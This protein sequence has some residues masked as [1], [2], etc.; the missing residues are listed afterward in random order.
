[1]KCAPGRYVLTPFAAP[2]G[3]TRAAPMPAEPVGD[4]ECLR[5]REVR[6][7]CP[8]RRLAV[9]PW[10]TGAS[11]RLV[12][13]GLLVC[14]AT[15]RDAAGQ[16]PS[17]E[18]EASPA[19]LMEDSGGTDVR[20][21]AT[22][23]ASRSASTVVTLSLGGEARPG[24]P[25][26]GDYTVSPA[27]PVITIPS[28][29]TESSVTLVVNPVDDT[30]WEQD[31][32]ITVDGS[33]SGVTVTGDFFVIADDEQAPGLE[34]GFDSGFHRLRPGRSFTDTVALRLTGDSTFE[35]A[36]TVTVD[37]EG[38]SEYYTAT[39]PFPLSLTLPAGATS[40]KSA[41]VRVE[42]ASEIAAER[43]FLLNASFDDHPSVADGN[44]GFTIRPE[45]L[46]Y[47]ITYF[48][49]DPGSIAA[50]A[51]SVS[52]DATMRIS[53]A[54]TEDLTAVVSSTNTSAVSD[55]F[56]FEFS[57]ET[58]EAMATATIVAPSSAASLY[59]TPPSATDD[60][61]FS[62]NI[63]LLPVYDSML[64]VGDIG[65]S[66][67][68][69]AAG[70]DFL[71]TGGYFVV[72]IYLNQSFSTDSGPTLAITLDSGP[73]ITAPCSF[74]RAGSTTLRCNYYVRAGD[75]DEDKVI[76][77]DSG[78]LDFGG[79]TLRSPYD[80]NIVFATPV[81]PPGPISIT[82]PKR[83]VGG[84]DE[85][86][87][88]ASLES[89]QEGVGPAQV[90]VTATRSGVY[91][92][93]TAPRNI[94]IPL[95]FVDGT[96]TAGDYS[97][98]GTRT[99]TI[100]R[101]QAS[102]TTTLT[103]TAVDDFVKENRT[104]VVRIE[105]EMV[106]EAVYGTALNVIDAPNILLSALP[107]RVAEDGGVQTVTVTA[108]LGDPTDSVRPRPIPVALRLGGSAVENDDFTVAGTLE[109]TIPANQRSGTTM[110]TLTPVD[111]R[112]LE[113]S[114]TIVLEG[115]TAGL[116]VVGTEV[117]LTDD[118]MQPQV[119]LEVDDDT[120]EE[121]EASAT[122][123]SVTAR[124]DPSVMVSADTVVTL[125]LGGTATEGASG[126][127]TASW[128]PAARQLTVPAGSSESS[129]A[130]TLTLTPRQDALPEGDETIV[131]EGTAEVSNPAM[132][133]LS[134]VVARITLT[135]DDVAGVEVTPT[136]LEIDE[137]ESESYMVALE[138][139]P[140]GDVTFGMTAALAG[141]DV[142][143]S[144]TSL[145]F[146]TT[147]WSM[148]QPVTVTAAADADADTDEPVTLTHSVRG[149]GYDA[150]DDV[151][152]VVVTIVEDDE[153]TFTLDVLPALID[154]DGGVS[155]VTV[156]TVAGVTSTSEETITLS[157][158]GTAT[159]GVDYRVASE[160]LV[161]PAGDTSVTTTVTGLDD[162]A[163]EGS[164]TVVVAATHAGA[165]AGTAQ[166]ITLAEST[167]PTVTL[168]LAPQSIGEN[169]GVSTVTA[170]LSHASSE[171]VA[172]TVS[173]AAVSPAV[174]GDF[175]LSPNK[176]LT[177]A[178]GQTASTG[179]VTIS[180]V[181]NAVDSPDK[182]VTVSATVSGG[183]GAS[184]PES[185]T[186]TIEDD[187]AL[188][189]VAL[190]LTPSSIG[191][192]GGV[193]TV[194]ATLSPASSESVEVTVSA[195]AVSPAVSGDFELSANLVLTIAA[196]ETT[197][198]GTVTV[199]AVNNGVDAPNKTVTVSGSVTGGNGVS[200]P[201][202]QPLTI[203][204]DETA[205]TVNLVLTPSSIGEN[206]GVSTV[207]ATLSPA[208]SESV[209]VTVSAAA[210]SPAVSGDFSLSANRVL[211]I[212]AGETT[213]TG[214]VTVTAVN[215]GVDAP[216]KTVT[217]SGSVTGGNG[218]SAPTDRT[219]TIS[220]DET[221]PTVNLV[222]TPSSIGENGGVSTVTATLSP[223][224]SESVAVTM[225]AT[226]DS[227]AVS[228][229]FSLSANRVLTIAAGETTSTGTVTVTA[230]NNAV[231]APNKTV[232]VSASVTG[233]NGVSAPTDR[234]LTIS[235]DE[236][237]P[238]VALVLTPSSIGENGGVSTVTATLSPASSESVAV[239]VSATAVSP[240]VS[241]DFSLSANQVLTIAAG[242]TT[243]TGTVTITAVNNG[244]DAP[245]K[246][247]TVSGSATGGNG[248]SAPTD[249]TL[250]ISD[251]E[252]APTVNLVL[253]PS[254][255]GENGGVSTVTAT[256]SGVSSEAVEV[257]VSATPVSPAVSGDFELSA[258]L[259]LT[260]AA[261]ETTS[262]GTVTVTAVNNGVDAPAKTVT[263][264][265]SVTGGNGVSAPT[266]QTL[267]ISDDDALPTVNLALT[268][269]S[270][271][272]N[273]G[274]ST[275]TATLS[276]VS[277]ES[278]AVT[279]SATADSPAVSG[280]FELS[281]NQ[282]LTI[283]AG[284]T[285]STGTVTV[286][287]VNNGVDAPNKT[288]TV[289]ASVTGGNGV[290]APSDQVLTISDD[291][292]L[293]T[294]NLVL[295]PSSIGENGGVST[296]T[297]TLSGVSS[298]AVEVTV[299]ATPVS[300][301]VSGD[302]EL[303]ANQVLTIAAG[304][305][306]STGTVTV[307][308]V[309][310]GVDAP[311][312]T[313][314][315]SASVTGGNGVSAPSDQTLTISDDDAL[316]TV[317]LVLAP[318]SIGED[319]GV[320]TV[321][322]TLSPASSEAVEV[323]VSATADSPA[324]SGDFE[325]SANL[326]LTIAA[327]ET[328]STGTVTVT[329]VNNGVDAPN[330][331]VTVSG[332][333]TGGNGASAPASR[334][335]TIS[336]DETTPT[337]N[338]VLTPSSIGE[339]GGVSTVTATLSP[340]SSE[341]V[342]VT[343]SATADSP[344]V[345]GDFSLSPNLVLTI[346]AG[347]TTSTGTVTVT[348]VNNAVDAP[349]KTVTVSG[350]VTGGNGVS[351]P[352]DRTLTISDD[353]TAPTVNLVLT[354]SSIGENG[355]VST[356][357]ATLS[358]ASSES[359]AVTVSATADSPA[360]SG[361]FSLSANRVLTIGAGQTTSTGTVTVTAVNNA[362]DAPNKTV[363]V[364]GSVTGGNGVSAPS[365]QP[366]TISDDEGA[367]TVALVLTP[368]SIGENGG[369][370]T[371]TATL[372]PASSESVAVTVSATAV[373]PAVSGDF[374]LSANRVLTIAA[375][376]R[377]STGTVT[378]TA[379]NNGV[380][381][382]NK[383]VTVSAS[384]T[385]GNGVSVPSDQTLTISDD[386]ALP[387]VSL[388]L[389][390]S[391]IGENGGVSTVTATLSGVSS[392]S[393]A[394]T[395]SATA[396]SPAVSG[397][398]SLSANRVLTIA[399]GQRSSTGTVTITAVNNAVDAPNKTVTVSGSVTGGNGASAPASR[400]LTISDD[401][402]TPTVN[403][404]LTPS[405]IGENG[406]VSTV[407]ATLSPASSE[408]VA[409][410]VSA[411]AV[412]PAVSGDFSLS[413]N[414]V[415]TI[416][417]G[418]TTST[419]TVTVTAVN[420]AVDAPNKT[421]TVSGSVTGGNGV[422]APTDRTL[423]ISDDETAPTVNLVLTP[424][425]IGENGGV[426]TVT[427][428][429]SGVSSESV[430]V[431]VS[432]TA[433]SPAVSGDFSLSANRVL[434]I[435]AGQTTSTG[436]VTITAVNNAVD[437]PAKTVTVSGS[438]TGGNGVSAPSDQP[439]T[440]SDDETTP[441]VA[442]A[443][444]P[445]SIGENGGV[446][447]VTATLSPASSEAVEVTVSATPLSPAV[448]DDFSLSANRVL[449]IAA[450]QTTSTGTVTI[451]A[452]N[453]GVDAP[454]KTVT[455]SG[456]VSGGNGVSAPGSQTLT[457]AD[458]EG[459]P[460]VSLV[461]N[462]SSVSEDDGLSTV[463]ATLSGVSSEAVTLMVS[464]AAVPPT[465]SGDFELSS[466]QV[467]TIAAGET[468][469]T[470]TVT[471]T[472]VDD[473]V[474]APNKTVR[475]SATVSGGN[476][477]SAPG[478][479][480]LTITDDEGAPTVSLVLM[481]SSIGENGGVSTV[482]ATL[483][484][485]SSEAVEVTVSATPV[486]P[487]VS[488]DF[489]L[490]ANPVLTIA[491]GQTASSGTVTI[492]AA[493]NAVDAP[494]K[495]VTVSGSVTGGNGLEAP[496]SQTLTITDDEGA[497]GVSL[498]LTP[499]S[500]GE[501]GGVSTVTATLSTASSETVTV[502]VSG[503]AVSP[504]VSGDFEL[505]AN[506]VLTIV[507]GQTASTGE[508]TITAVDDAVDGPAKEV[509]VSAT[510]TGGNGLEAP[511]SQ[512]LTIT[513][514]E[515]APGVSLV[516]TPPSIS[517][518]GGVSTVTATLSTASSE[519]VTV[520]VSGEAVSP[521]VSGDFEL[522]ANREL[523]ISAGQMASTGEVTITAVD[524]AVGGPG[525]EV[526]VSATVD[527]GNGLEAP[528]PQTLT[529]TDD[530]GALEVSLVL[531][532]SSIGENGGVSTVTATLS[533]ASSESVTVMVSG[534]A[535]SPAVS[536]DFELSANRELT[537]AAGQTAST[538][539]VTI[540]AVDDEL[541]GPNK[542]VQVSGS[543]TGG[544]GV[545]APAP[546]TLT[547]TED[548]EPQGVLLSVEPSQVDEG[549]GDRVV[550][551]TA[552]HAGEAPTEETVL[553]VSIAG[554]T[555]DEEDDFTPVEQFELR[556]PGS[557]GA[558]TAS[559]TLT[560][561]DDEL[562][563]GPETLDVLGSAENGQPVTPASLTIVDDDLV[564]VLLSVEPSTVGED[565]GETDVTVT[566]TL[567]GGTRLVPLV[568]TVTVSEN[569]EQYAV[570][571]AVF[572]VE[573]PAEETR[574]TGVFVL[575]PVDDDEEESDEQVMVTGT[576]K[577]L[578]VEPAAVMIR[579]DDENAAPA[580]DR[581]RHVFELPENRSG[582]ETP[583]VLG[584]VV[585]S[586]ADGDRL[587]YVLESGDRD[588]FRIGGRD[589]RVSYVGEGED[590]EADA[591]EYELTV[592]AHDGTANTE[593]EVLVRVVDLPEAP[594]AADDRAETPEDTPKVID[595]LA[596]DSD[597]DGDRL[598][599]RSVTAPEHG[600]AAVVSGGVR[601]EPELNWHG[602]DRFTYTVADPGGLTSRATVVVTV[603][604]VNDPPE[605][606]DD[607]AE[608]LEDVPVVVDVLANDTDVDGDPLRVVSVGAAGH[609]TT[610]AAGGGV[611][612]ASHL[613]WYGT[614]RFTYTIADPEGLTSTATVTMTVLPVNDP[615]EA[616]GVIPDQAIEEG[617][618]SASVELLPY[619][620]DVDGDVLTYEAVSSDE[621]AVTV[622]VSGSTL[623]LTAV[624]TGTAVVTVTAS[625]V[626]GLTATQRFGV[627]VGDRL[628]KAV[629]TD[630]LAALGRGHL[631]SARMTIGRLLETDGG[632]MTRLMVAGQQ[633]SLGAW[634]RMGAGGL[635]QTHELLFRAATLQQR[636]SA[637]NLV[638]TSADPR[639]RRP[640]ASGIMGGGFG[641]IGGDRNPLFQGTDV[642]LSF[643]G[644]DGP[645]GGGGGA[646]RWRVW[647]QGDMQSFRGAATETSGYDGDLRTAY[648]GL[649]ARLNEQWLAGV[650]VARSGG[651]GNW[652]VGSSSGRLTT[653]LT[654]LH[655]YL[656][657][658]GQDTAVWAL[659]GIGRGTADN[660]RA[661]TGKRGA[662]PLSLALGLVEARRRLGTL[663]GRV[664]LDLRGEA[665]WARLATGGGDETI[666]DLAAGVRRV[667]TGVEVTLPMGG[668]GGAEVAPFGA[669]STRHDGG[670]GQTGVGLEFAGG[671]RVTHGTVRVEAQ[672]R[673]LAL[674][675]ATGY[676][677]R[678]FG[679][680]ATVGGGQHEPGLSASLR[681]HWGAQG[682][683]AET[684]WQEQFQA[685]TQDAGRADAG[686]DGRVGY[687][688]RMPGGR[689]LTPF[690]GYGRMGGGRRLQLG[691]NLGMA[692]LFGG[693]LDSPVQVEFIGER[694]G[695]PGVAP[696]HRVT[697]FGI[698]NFGA[699]SRA[700][701][702]PAEGACVGVA[703]D[704]GV[705]P[706]PPPAAARDEP[707]RLDRAVAPVP[708]VADAVPRVQ[709]GTVAVVPFVNASGAPADEWV[710]AGM[711]ETLAMAFQRLDAVSIFGPGRLT[712]GARAPGSG[713]S[714][715]GAA[716]PERALREVARKHGASWLVSGEY[717]RAGDQVWVTAYL[718]DTGTGA[719][720][721]DVAANGAV[722]DL[723]A[724][725]DRLGAAL[726]D[727]LVSSLAGS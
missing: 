279:V 610:A 564:A 278:V 174:A 385:G 292:A 484:G 359:V 463:T 635:E 208:S 490:S 605:A 679:V 62:G 130:V 124:L 639:L 312:K 300:P 677:E 290:S 34:I 52:V 205:P 226:A 304:Q 109:V 596:N 37:V 489:E 296:V 680:T 483:S 218:V 161:L 541:F 398:F 598:R 687:G 535:V 468:T 230:V 724:L 645:A 67:T 159:K 353:E 183:K 70:A 358:P 91:G 533:T 409:V 379:V 330:K 303:S 682:V 287:A 395:V 136:A 102:G 685:Y 314:T 631:S 294:V 607:E 402:T 239:T 485:V 671:L 241:G 122:M 306:S 152:D 452:V 626:E 407:T 583:V 628:V 299:S 93:Q 600:T 43:S 178:A 61:F 715:T 566:A 556:I 261:G 632:A 285:T 669:V 657:W 674:H 441:T 277:S 106:P 562:N 467:L 376:Q 170:S 552:T 211:T 252:T 10:R 496:A 333:V 206:G 613:N 597:A 387:T 342:A 326:V 13:A 24:G 129:S 525:K 718:V 16:Q 518:N 361:D 173:G 213:S 590:Y 444:T 591:P 512:T 356:V 661:L 648:L 390:P 574:G 710:G 637:T 289:S 73:G 321:T 215:N 223:A 516:L 151:D 262:T 12:L 481:P 193:S 126:D 346:A 551:V 579:D 486:S 19:T 77:L 186:L 244:V 269:S 7:A 435:A 495:T 469:S 168:A 522:S 352:T 324:V 531:T 524:D 421:V 389:T 201:P 158:T 534:E 121:G 528:A 470:G 259:V 368:S 220:D 233:G 649:D 532:P 265:G 341:S 313:V 141:T 295:A 192:N 427:A 360:V 27:S 315:V 6:P 64:S 584:T 224:S 569:A 38:A 74:S 171:S 80:D 243:S 184:A 309:N 276:G 652:E 684:L 232:T 641:G 488:G 103:V 696:D 651:A 464:A 123:V 180:A 377:S 143:V 383:T 585:A 78:A 478:S 139:Q 440:I 603:T 107:A 462:P 246:T 656:R 513:D 17:V 401:E 471:V 35:S 336:D 540:T 264:S 283:A 234:T 434:T 454:N 545:E 487:A 374:S 203:S 704:R 362:V 413:A 426:S 550:Q 659:A 133:P 281:A 328:T 219:L 334:R 544:N 154:E 79:Q 98:S 714:A 140:T 55:P 236:T 570:A 228:G 82:I 202:D 492:T 498:V 108:A 274:V 311:N 587:R 448:S 523:T 630:A 580:F 33:A 410:T 675:T 181:N 99:I 320:S 319:G 53:P 153:L 424:S 56:V 559:F 391:S 499:S 429:L 125:D 15:A 665:S 619:F 404:V 439:L 536:G 182:E 175:S 25:G 709:T 693:D 111:D 493:D 713:M 375:G 417:A 705:A 460:T 157:L 520:T 32:E 690:G 195:A 40:V 521:A 65:S 97:V 695:R 21:T 217:V 345:S 49:F 28:G 310:N 716:V 298:E 698:V 388:V 76:Q 476:G 547:I 418:E 555:A 335:L 167:P 85:I 442:L 717:R 179:T 458:D 654:V 225:S 408:S 592:S 586:D 69:G 405:S 446:S 595:V 165:A 270:I 508:V 114:E 414:L 367:P 723:F 617:G 45:R 633:L 396:D 30:Y 430:A 644:D 364:S 673:M 719:R 543:V 222:L 51:G 688:L 318:Q 482:T 616:V 456:S 694:Y 668:P 428:T 571:P 726:T 331:T 423:T 267:T 453:D 678:G 602:K 627:Q 378:I 256:L 509:T 156:S 59:F 504:A 706:H 132:D 176:V 142:S 664:E 348:A 575:T 253:T 260:I 707:G 582:R 640:G 338:L 275:V 443:L 207:T 339:N 503:E 355:G 497:P 8:S 118:D 3:K 284:E 187:D 662:S 189:T 297:A 539:E 629:L 623:T 340:A 332:S 473:T 47:R 451:T 507:A 501:N 437:A 251:D 614:D 214:T 188:P 301:A 608:T 370:S 622:A 479:Q 101:G 568:V 625:D 672:G 457:I 721:A 565:A 419:G 445:S 343:V 112:L 248:V 589:G 365:D 104:E 542:Q 191:E 150:V 155:T 197:S 58:T 347:Q 100:P 432:A 87:L 337:V 700:P 9:A 393:V 135:D 578:E 237:A 308:A 68:G 691:A 561:V 227:P 386:D 144:P 455:V 382:P 258:N 26:V 477:V 160:T 416:A 515:G 638:G 692:G 538:G 54:P 329:A 624:V 50:G 280:D 110:L 162:S 420:N 272:E 433:D 146:T 366:L 42:A 199:T 357:T 465:V 526:T 4:A 84:T 384:V 266:D 400:R 172:V 263:V 212:A 288:V 20:V 117:T 660:V 94:P 293:P 22:L 670:A 302:F 66:G 145:T 257:T 245:N 406:G 411:T 655:P 514:D 615:P 210:V 282:V 530:E 666:D 255:I 620:T 722:E 354:P 204:D 701:C 116:T 712:D 611:R 119:I 147:D 105:A 46:E 658:G 621:T 506:Q 41:A 472:A 699:R 676:E 249:R 560:P 609:G 271:G 449:T 604:P 36:E 72:H 702:N 349:N 177:I 634:E 71:L 305:R 558:G 134:V 327:G 373:S 567:T 88:L 369:V 81:V 63:P 95:A 399:A 31:E 164:E 425:S 727:A 519:A 137:G 200:A 392:E 254:S 494:E 573:I 39:P 681:P 11:V 268:P 577:P 163:V 689:L 394:V 546:R 29:E 537:I 593:A 708:P 612:Y 461:L 60:Y 185:V 57:A 500:I 642:L 572:D 517:E 703:S 350:S 18:L 474:D 601:Y 436:T 372:S 351:A 323:T 2:A 380:D 686:F 5:A 131:V 44:S 316:P 322:A 190:V 502:T 242:E 505:S 576:T 216:N 169:G 128:S 650:A 450:G 720:A 599:V 459:A 554:D 415:L 588:R 273:G 663:A 594:D 683:G 317:N 447:T 412:S 89:L 166:T 510:V 1:M 549:G 563:E 138:S 196:G 240:A 653:D 286:T 90:V 120:I 557:A 363:T 422:S 553:T 291:D 491:A 92:S 725:Q 480:T 115:T 247:V 397:D 466:N 198:T 83:V 48:A 697:L 231:D 431:T 643:G 250:T 149:G 403:L 113:M 381:A 221:T 646:G 475:V 23:S 148:S 647:G 229:D 96:T 86:S 711:A 548:E 344:A 636:L 238:T 529:I 667:R 581:R 14:G 325:L 194:T 209:A 235:D 438:V 307:T 511:A 371:V 127:Y 606:V 75:S 618:A 527:G